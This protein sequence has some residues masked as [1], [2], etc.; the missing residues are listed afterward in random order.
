MSEASFRIRYESEKPNYH[1]MDAAYL[2]E[3]LMGLSEMGRVAYRV[4]RPEETHTLQ[5]RVNALEAG[6]FAID[7]AAVIPPLEHLYGQLV[8]FFTSPDTT[9]IATAGSCVT[10]LGSAIGLVKWIAGRKHSAERNGDTTTIT[11][12]DGDQTEVPT[13]VYNISGNATFLQAATHALKPLDD[14]TYDRMQIQDASGNVVAQIEEDERGYFAVN[15]DAKDKD[16]TLDLEVVVE[17]VQLADSRR[18]W[19]FRSGNQKFNAKVQD[20]EFLNQIKKDG[21]YVTGDT[22]LMVSRR[23]VRKVQPSGEA[24]SSYYITKVHEIRNQGQDSLFS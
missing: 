2:A 8:G 6:S 17:T 13:V 7:L 16:E 19:T 4:M 15:P 23:E 22:R 24:K 5:V 10:A 14:P 11:T 21:L 12:T 1:E 9:A 3:A 18:M 20:E